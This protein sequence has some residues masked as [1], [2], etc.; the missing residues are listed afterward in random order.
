MLLNYIKFDILF[1]GA[2]KLLEGKG[3]TKNSTFKLQPHGSTP[4]DRSAYGT[5]HLIEYNTYLS[6]I[7]LYMQ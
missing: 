5:V 1:R 4:S 3:R 7:D 2:P 6:V